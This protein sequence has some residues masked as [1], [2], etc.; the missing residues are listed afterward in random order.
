VEKAIIDKKNKILTGEKFAIKLIP[1][2][3]DKI[4]MLY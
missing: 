2:S 4:N 1:G 3:I